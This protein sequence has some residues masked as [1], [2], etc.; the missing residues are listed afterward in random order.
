[1]RGRRMIRMVIRRSGRMREGCYK[2]RLQGREG[3]GEEE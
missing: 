2:G 1:M 3:R